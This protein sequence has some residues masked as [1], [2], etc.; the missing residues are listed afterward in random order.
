MDE[1]YRSNA[2][3]F[4]LDEVQKHDRDRYLALL[5]TPP[6]ARRHLVALYAFNAEIARIRETVT[7]PLLGEMRLQWWRDG[8]H[9]QG[10]KAAHPA[11]ALLKESFTAAGHGIDCLDDLI[12]G[13]RGDLYD[14]EPESWEDL[15]HYLKATSSALMVAALKILNAARPETVARA[16]S[17]GL[18]Y[19]Y[20]GLARSLEFQRCQGRCLLPRRHWRELSAGREDYIRY[21]RG[22][23]EIRQAF[24]NRA[25]DI[26]ASLPSG[27]V[28]KDAW[29]A[30]LPT[31]CARAHL[32]ALQR[33]R[34]G[35]GPLALQ[36]ALLWQS[37]LRR[38]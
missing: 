32:R 12:D 29:P 37:S 4:C 1:Q 10:G 17:L 13:R 14:E 25:A 36:W 16:E 28:E 3:A 7:Q 26:F 18:A 31:I 19:G 30:L 5:A 38:L 2:Q 21:G 35:A 9:G 8:L 20:A 27:K 11:M 24:I 23:G 15:E 22:L 6:E 34:N 33:G